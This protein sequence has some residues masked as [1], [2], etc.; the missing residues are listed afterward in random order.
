MKQFCYAILMGLCI[1]SC[2]AQITQVNDMKEVTEYFTN[3][4]AKTL[5]IFDV[6]MVLI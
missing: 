4:D 2:H 5:A 1:F 3:A 6:D